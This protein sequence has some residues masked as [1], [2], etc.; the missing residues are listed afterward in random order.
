M[1]KQFPNK[2]K[3]CKAAERGPE[4]SGVVRQRPTPPFDVAGGWTEQ[5]IALSKYSFE[6]LLPADPDGV[7]EAQLEAEQA[8]EGADATAAGD[9]YWAA[10]WSSASPTAEAVLR[11]RWRAEDRAMEIG[12]GMGLVGLAALARGMQVTFSDHVPQAIEL[13]LHNALRNGFCTARGARVDW[14]DPPETP[15]DQPYDVILASDILYHRGSHDPILNTVDRFLADNGVCWI[16]DPGRFNSRDFLRAARRRFDVQLR[17]QAGQ[18]LSA[19]RSA[20]YQMFVL[21]H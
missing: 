6:V 1:A 17:D 16:G 11:A 12:C 21:R 20:Q 5:T 18:L 13:A 15:P 14:R 4:R 2:L 7:L 10:L 9:P 19:P 8:N 3:D